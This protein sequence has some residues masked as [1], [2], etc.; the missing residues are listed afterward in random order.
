MSVR[1]LAGVLVGTVLVVAGAQLKHEAIAPHPHLAIGCGGIDLNVG[2]EVN[3]PGG[4]HLSVPRPMQKLIDAL[5]P[6]DTIVEDDGRL[7]RG[8]RVLINGDPV[9][10][11]RRKELEP[12]L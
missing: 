6:L 3:R 8:I 12:F 9:R 2:D 5:R 4:R 11:I 10:T 7:S 1:S